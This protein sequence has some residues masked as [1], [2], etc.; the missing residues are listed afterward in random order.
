MRNIVIIAGRGKLAGSIIH[1]LNNYNGDYTIDLF[2]NIGHYPAEQVII[3]HI[4][5][6]RQLDA[7]IDYCSLN[8]VPLIQGST[9]MPPAKQDYN[10]TFIDAP[11][12]NILMLKFMYMLREFGMLYSGCDI[13]IIESHQHTKKTAAGTAA[14]IARSLGVDSSY[15][16]SIRDRHE[17]VNSL[18][19]PHEYLD[20]HAFHQITIEEAGTMLNF[21][22]LVK[23]HESYLKGLSM[24]ILALDKLENRYYHVLDLINMKLV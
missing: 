1:G 7:V 21:T 23:G 19:I 4:G 9:G 6:G 3:V 14:G 16:K 8:R 18:K 20:L 13:S 24:I 15:I 22:T 5:S 17:Q 11:N 12:F 2:E 10:F